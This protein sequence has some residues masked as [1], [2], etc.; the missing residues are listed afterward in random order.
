[1]I[2]GV[3]IGVF[4]CHIGYFILVGVSILFYFR[5]PS[6]AHTATQGSQTM[7]EFVSRERTAINKD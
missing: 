3:R 1:M 4:F 7:L 5:R 6:A 2:S